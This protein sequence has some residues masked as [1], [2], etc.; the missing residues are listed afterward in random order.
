MTQIFAYLPPF[1]KR[2][3]GKGG[4]RGWEEDKIKTPFLVR[5]GAVFMYA[6]VVK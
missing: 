1:P 3:E 5:K 2:S 4:L 6:I